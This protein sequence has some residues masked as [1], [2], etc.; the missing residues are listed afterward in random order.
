VLQAKR[1]VFWDEFSPVEFAELGVMTVT[2]FKKAFGG[3]YFEVRAAATCTA[4]IVSRGLFARP[5]RIHIVLALFRSRCRRMRTTATWTS[6]GSA[7]ASS[8]T[9]I[10]AHTHT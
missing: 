9:R 6:V 2:Q 7:V 8:P 4:R 10:A 5:R 3:Q 1:F